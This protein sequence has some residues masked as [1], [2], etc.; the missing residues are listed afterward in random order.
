MKVKTHVE[1]SLGANPAEAAF[2]PADSVAMGV[3]RWLASGR[4]Q[5]FRALVHRE[6][7][8]LFLA[9]L[10]NQTGFWVAHLSIQ[11]LTVA[12][13]DND[14][15]HIGMV[16]F[17]LFLPAFA[18]A[19]L[20]GVAAD[21]FDRKRIVVV[22]YAAVV[23][24]ALVLSALTHAGRMT[25]PWLLGLTFL[26]GTAFSF[27]GPANMAIA[28]NSV[29][30]EDLAS[31]VSLQSA[32]NNL[33]RV[34]GPMVA[35]PLVATGRFDVAFGAYAIAATAAG[36]LV[37]RMHLSP[38]ERPVEEALGLFGRI[39]SGFAHARERR[40]ALPALAM[41][42]MLS[43]F[44]ASHVTLLSIYAQD[45][46]GDLRWFP[47]IVSAIGAGA[48][49]GALVTGG[50]RPRLHGAAW[51]ALAYGVLLSAFGLASHP[52][53][54]IGIEALIGYFYFAVMTELQ[55][56]IQGIVD[57]SM[58][59]RVMSLFQVC[60]AGLIPFGSLGMGA[61]AGAIG[62]SAT[63]VLAGVACAGCG[64]WMALRAEP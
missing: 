3:P 22:C 11:G 39:A 38:W 49:V 15:L 54:A 45:R 6:Y 16:F 29:P 58:R 51:H 2:D 40:P 35:G 20:A 30:R 25:M 27:S 33:T 55:T 32:M 10:I 31:A 61:A 60:W 24:L 4:G 34:V 5:V 9:F 48:L 52:A 21:H 44:G 50:R 57:E 37:A 26:L 8:L 64:L 13:S 56:L 14:P 46:L 36:L 63:L 17:S 41:V 19:P 47:W 18:L 1:E 28:A 42:G 12:I 7:R 62:V 43:I 59:G 23:G 53:L